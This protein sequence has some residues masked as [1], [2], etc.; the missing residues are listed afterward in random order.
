MIKDLR[1]QMGLS[2]SQF[3]ERFG[4]PVRTIQQWEQGK[5]SPPSYV[6]DMMVKLAGY[7]EP[8]IIE[9]VRKRSVGDTP[10]VNYSIPTSDRWKICIDDAFT[11]CEK[12]Y[13]IQQRKVRE[14][15]DDARRNKA[16]KQIVIFGSSVTN[17][18]HV[19]SDVDVFFEMTKDMNPLKEAH[20]FEIDAWNNYNAN[21]RMKNEITKKGVIVYERGDVV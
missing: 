9:K 7:S 16:V 11:N 19:G 4:I 6:S 5:S 15:I 17:Q 21:S 14:I 18:C 20:D 13:P 3:A 12:I 2:Q 10:L 8:I 1:Q